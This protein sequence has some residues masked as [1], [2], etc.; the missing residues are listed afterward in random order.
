MENNPQCS[1]TYIDRAGLYEVIPE[2]S[3]PDDVD[4]KKLSH[5]DTHESF[6]E[7]ATTE[8]E[9]ENKTKSRERIKG[10]KT[11]SKK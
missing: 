9:G 6:A 3:F 7:R 5:Y 1:P 2:K 8:G 4:M 11:L 10:S